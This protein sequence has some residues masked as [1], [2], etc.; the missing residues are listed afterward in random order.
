MINEGGRI[1][2]PLSTLFIVV[3]ISLGE[4]FFKTKPFTLACTSFKISS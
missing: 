3:I 1:V 4:E 2:D